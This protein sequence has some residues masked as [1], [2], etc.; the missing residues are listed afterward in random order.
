MSAPVIPTTQSDRQ[1]MEAITLALRKLYATIALIN[2]RLLTTSATANGQSVPLV[3][4]AGK[5]NA[6]QH[7]LGRP[8]RGW[9]VVNANAAATLYQSASTN[10]APNQQILLV[11]SATVTVSLWVF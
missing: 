6:V 1:I 8:A 3:L 7:S 9:F 2:G 4:T 10:P 5:D 11:T